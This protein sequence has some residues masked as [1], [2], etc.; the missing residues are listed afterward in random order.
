MKIM[1]T[2]RTFGNLKTR[3]IAS[4]GSLALINR[5]EKLCSGLE[6]SVTV[7]TRAQCKETPALAF[8][9]EYVFL[10]MMHQ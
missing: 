10:L 9:I 6:S 3:K 8:G 2:K 5:Q 7:S 1:S 4:L